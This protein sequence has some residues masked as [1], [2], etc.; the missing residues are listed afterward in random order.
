MNSPPDT[1]GNGE[2]E[3][4]ADRP[5]PEAVDYA[6]VARIST[7]A[8]LRAIRLVYLH[9]DVDER[10]GAIPSDWSGEAVMGLNAG[11]EFDRD[12]SALV[13]TCGFLAMWV[14]GL[15]EEL[16]AL[17]SPEDAPLELHARFRLSYE[18]KDPSG[19]QDADPEHFAWS[20]GMLHAWPYWREIAHSTTV[21]MG[22]APLVVGTFKIPWSR[23][24]DRR[25]QAD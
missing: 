11:F 22:L 7:Q 17:P 21:R 2:R 15:E 14:P 6:A 10:K 5:L 23:D 13:I 19:V 25:E 18:L 8:D 12:S 9:A 1:P 3:L 4:R 24:P 16:D 20:N